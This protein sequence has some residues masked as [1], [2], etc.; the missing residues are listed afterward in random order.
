MFSNPSVC[1]NNT[2]FRKLWTNFSP[3]CRFGN[4]RF[5]SSSTIHILLFNLIEIPAWAEVHEI[6]QP[7]CDLDIKVA[8]RV[9]S[10]SWAAAAWCWWQ[11][12]HSWLWFDKVIRR[13]T[14]AGYIKPTR[15]SCAGDTSADG[16]MTSSVQLLNSL[17]T[18]GL[19]LIWRLVLFTRHD[20]RAQLN[21]IGFN[22][23]SQIKRT[24][25][26]AVAP[27]FRSIQ[28]SWTRGW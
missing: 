3:H 19:R 16:G 6:K 2:T 4:N 23:W 17:V 22:K 14:L 28:G 12:R 25:R 21:R 26:Q 13:R 7:R 24:S 10:G 20:A 18:S 1:I 15:S 9:L 8:V 5:E 27:R 11:W